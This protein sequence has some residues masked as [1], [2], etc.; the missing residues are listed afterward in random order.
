LEWRRV[1]RKELGK[2]ANWVG[3]RVVK[4]VAVRA[5]HLGGMMVARW[6]ERMGAKWAGMRVESKVESLAASMAGKW[7]TEKVD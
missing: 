1:E 2:V 4:M 7:G 6:V 5:V 3:Q